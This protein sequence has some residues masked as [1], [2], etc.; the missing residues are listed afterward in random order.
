MCEMVLF[1]IF[2]NISL[3]TQLAFV[4]H[5]LRDFYVFHDHIVSFL[6][7][8][9]DR[10]LVFLKEYKYIEKEKRLKIYIED[11]LKYSSDEKASDKDLS[12]Y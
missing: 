10:F 3:N 5:F 8:S 11:D 4:F 12:K 7:F 1:S 2:Y 6:L 9:L